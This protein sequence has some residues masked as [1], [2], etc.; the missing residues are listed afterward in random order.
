MLV[1]CEAALERSSRRATERWRWQPASNGDRAANP[2]PAPNCGDQNRC[3]MSRGRGLSSGDGGLCQRIMKSRAP[4]DPRAAGS[5]SAVTAPLA[6]SKAVA[7]DRLCGGDRAHA[8]WVGRVLDGWPR[9]RSLSGTRR[10]ASCA[11]LRRANEGS[12]SGSLKREQ[13]RQRGKAVVL[14]PGASQSGRAAWCG[15][16][17]LTPPRARRPSRRRVSGWRASAGTRG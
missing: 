12:R 15:P 6:P 17:P 13:A 1:A 11:A 7:H 2:L 8:L 3:R 14:L 10:Q 16:G 9:A 5:W 4:R